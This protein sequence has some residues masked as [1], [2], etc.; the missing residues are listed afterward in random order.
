M[1][2]TITLSAEMIAVV[3]DALRFAITHEYWSH[4]SNGHGYD[5]DTD[6]AIALFE[7]LHKGGKS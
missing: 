2:H 5:V 1:N 7:E 4:H 3:R 6:D